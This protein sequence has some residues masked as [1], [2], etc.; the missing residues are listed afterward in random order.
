MPARLSPP[1]RSPPALFPT[2]PAGTH[3]GLSAIRFHGSAPALPRS[4]DRLAKSELP[5]TLA[6]GCPQSPRATGALG[7][8]PDSG[9]FRAGA[10]GPPGTTPWAA[11]AWHPSGRCRHPSQR[12]LLLRLAARRL[13]PVLLRV[14]PQ[15]DRRPPRTATAGAGRPLRYA[16]GVGPTG[17]EPQRSGLPLGSRWA[18]PTRCVDL[19]P[20]YTAPGRTPVARPVPAPGTDPAEGIAI[21]G[22]WHREEPPVVPTATLLSAPVQPARNQGEEP[23]GDYPSVLTAPPPTLNP[24]FP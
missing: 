24:G 6:L 22:G 11:G 2:R 17:R 8:A 5:Q 3:A 15:R 14:R 1:E 13:A 4:V 7:P 10:G 23:P 12:L 18:R 19:F 9:P 21:P 20:A 16:D